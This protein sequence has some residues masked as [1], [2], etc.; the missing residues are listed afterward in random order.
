VKKAGGFFS[1]GKKKVA[2]E[3]WNFLIYNF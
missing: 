1:W 3:K 2:P